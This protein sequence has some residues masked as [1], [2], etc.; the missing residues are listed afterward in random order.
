M[1][2]ARRK[3]PPAVA[4]AKALILKEVIQRAAGT[5]ASHGEPLWKQISARSG[6]RASKKMRPTS[7]ETPRVMAEPL[8]LTLLIDRGTSNSPNASF[9]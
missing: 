9:P 4:V 7:K 3:S 8:S 6:T 2:S 5:S 1:L